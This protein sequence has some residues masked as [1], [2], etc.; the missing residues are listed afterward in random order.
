MSAAGELWSRAEKGGRRLLRRSGLN[1]WRHYDV[2]LEAWRKLETSA[3]IR[4]LESEREAAIT[5]RSDK[6]AKVAA[7]FLAGGEGRC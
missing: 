2:A 1:R 5:G 3:A 4:L 7:T 6:L